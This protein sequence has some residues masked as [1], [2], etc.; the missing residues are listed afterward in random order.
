MIAEQPW[1]GRD[2]LAVRAELRELAQQGKVQDVVLGFDH[3][4]N[5]ILQAQATGGIFGLL[6]YI[7][8]LAMPFAFFARAVGRGARRGMPQFAPALA[9][10]L[11]VLSYFGFGLTEVIFWS[12]KGTMFYVLMVAL[13][14]GFCLTAKAEAQPGTETQS[15]I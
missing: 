15:G 8:I 11:V 14:M 10:M 3:L 2:P 13:L 12:L 7:G 6:A 5:D 4:H 1:F 9:G